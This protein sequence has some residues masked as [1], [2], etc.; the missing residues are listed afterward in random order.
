MIVPF[1]KVALKNL[2]LKTDCEKYPAV[3]KEAP[4][5]Y[6][7][8]LVFHPEGCIGCGICERVCSP[9]AISTVV[10]HREDGDYITRTFHMGSCTFCQTC[11]DFCP[12][13]T[14]EMSK[15]YNMVVTNEDDLKVTGTYK[16]KP[17]GVPSK[18]MNATYGTGNVLP[19][20]RKAP[21]GSSVDTA[22]FENPTLADQMNKAAQTEEAA[23][24]KQKASAQEAVLKAEASRE[25]KSLKYGHDN[26]LPGSPSSDT[27][28]TK[29]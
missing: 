21:A 18:K 20:M 5:A 23:M 25:K 19:D 2:F 1:M 17:R 29:K 14:I 28:E 7:G 13:H 8:R 4:A 12:R 24:A 26:V 16:K 11:V 15:D 6:R 27:P 3:P 10:E 22:K 9:Q